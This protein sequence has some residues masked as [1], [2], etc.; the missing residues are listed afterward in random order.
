MKFEG[1]LDDLSLWN[2]MLVLGLSFGGFRGIL[3]S[4]FMR[5]GGSEAYLI[6]WESEGVL[7]LSF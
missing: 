3:R 6:C 1:I 5:F 4:K 7:G 2:W